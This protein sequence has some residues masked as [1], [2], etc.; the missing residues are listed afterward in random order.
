ML[1]KLEPDTTTQTSGKE[2]AK[3]C[4]TLA[5][6]AACSLPAEAR[7]TEGFK[8][9]TRGPL[10]LNMAVASLDGKSRFFEL[11]G[12]LKERDIIRWPTTKQH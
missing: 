4:Y 6:I 9:P 5:W 10:L 3:M 8:A 1:G 12:P 7:L 11:F 2:K